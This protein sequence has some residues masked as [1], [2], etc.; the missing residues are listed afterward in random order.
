MW[1]YSGEIG[2]TGQNDKGA[3]KGVECRG[4]ADVDAAEE[5]IDGGA[6]QDG[7]EGIFLFRVDLAE[8]ARKGRGIVA[9]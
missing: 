3:D 6:E 1:Q 2:K 9:R 8:K 5:G 4:R 7:I